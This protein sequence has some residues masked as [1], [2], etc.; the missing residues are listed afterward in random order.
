MPF[1]TAEQEEKSV[2]IRFAALLCQSEINFDL[3]PKF[4][5]KSV[6]FMLKFKK[7]INFIGVNGKIA[8]ES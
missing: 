7:N 6:S 1:S 4:K 3:S 2:A 8:W 5:T